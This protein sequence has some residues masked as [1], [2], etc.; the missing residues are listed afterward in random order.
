MIHSAILGAFSALLVV[1]AIVSGCLSPT[2]QAK[3][4]SVEQAVCLDIETAASLIP[5]SAVQQAAED[6][7]LVC[8]DVPLATILQYIEDRFGAQADGGAPVATEYRPSPHVL[9]AKAA[10]AAK[11]SGGGR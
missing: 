3:V 1:I 9:A 10:R 5:P 7:G 2:T 4:V 11:V 8:T 6:I